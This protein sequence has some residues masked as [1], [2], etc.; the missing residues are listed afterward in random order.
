VTR[1]KGATAMASES[2][3]SEG[4]VPKEVKRH[5]LLSVFSAASNDVHCFGRVPVSVG[6]VDRK[7][8]YAS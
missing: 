3:M 4:Q 7:E 6:I 8:G 2:N 5:T 1:H